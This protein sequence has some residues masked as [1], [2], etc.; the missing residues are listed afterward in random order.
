MVRNRYIA[1]TSGR[2]G[3]ARALIVLCALGLAACAKPD[4]MGG[5]IEADLTQVSESSDARREYR[6]GTGATS[7]AVT[8]WR[9]TAEPVAV[10]LAVHG[11]GDYGSSTFSTA[12]EEW[13]ELGIVTYAYDQRGFGRNPSNGDWPGHDALITDLT[14]VAA[15]I[16]RQHP[17]KPLTLI[18]HS[19]GG[20]VVTAALGE[21]EIDVNRAVL[22]APALWGGD[23]LSPF[24]RA[25]AHTA[26]TLAPDKRWS[27]NGIIK[28]QA[29]DNI[30]MLRSLGKDP[31]YVRNPSSREFVGLIRLMDR[32][33]TA[34]PEVETPVLVIYGSKDEVVPEEPIEDAYAT[35]KGPKR[36]E[37][38]PTGWHMLLRDLKGDVV[39]KM[40]AEF[41]LEGI[42]AS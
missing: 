13:A 23:N 22:L 14:T 32:A 39:R 20:G 26:H 7:I 40:V 42:G 16:R 1:C 27:G 17:A 34:A 41:A 38:V 30:E 37:K 9:P 28:I 24:L 19:M 2:G 12:A 21:T 36:Y 31:L 15:L 3:A 10:I 11:Y 4:G 18:G 33:V 35:F 6:L 8:E 25:M 5:A 29:S